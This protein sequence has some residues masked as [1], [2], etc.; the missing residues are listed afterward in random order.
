MHMNNAP[1]Y[2]E[3]KAALLGG[4]LPLS[5]LQN[6]TL[7]FDM[8]E[9][10]LPQPLATTEVSIAGFSELFPPEAPLPH[11]L[12]SFPTG[13]VYKRWRGNM[14]TLHQLMGRGGDDW[15]DLLCIGYRLEEMGHWV[16][17]LSDIR[18][19]LRLAGFQDLKPRDV[20]RDLA[21]LANQSLEGRKRVRFRAA[22]IALD[23]LRG[24][25]IVRQ[26]GLLP[27]TPIGTLP[28]R[29]K[30]GSFR[31]D[32]PPGLK[33][34]ET[35]P[36][37][38]R[39]VIRTVHFTALKLG[40]VGADN[41]SPTELLDAITKD[42]RVFD[43]LALRMKPN[44]LKIYR[45]RAIRSLGELDTRPKGADLSWEAMGAALRQILPEESRSIVDR[46]GQLRSAAKKAGVLP[47]GVT[48]ALVAQWLAEASQDARGSIRVGAR[49]LNE[50]FELGEDFARFL[51]AEPI[52][53]SAL[54]GGT[55]VART[56]SLK[57]RCG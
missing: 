53:R 16:G 6:W 22:C 43:D 12:H 32:V 31:I 28:K 7:S 48:T 18:P 11:A 5:N 24:H 50:M 37:H 10:A 26:A 27:S 38:I 44:S 1:T 2:A 21:L 20:I 3:M 29:T 54:P 40:L 35:Y 56:K 39:D 46:F 52:D 33:I 57:E 49:L 51:P 8:F 15:S 14:L 4:M 34:F 41:V 9:R 17:N 13:P 45:Q 30:S 42:D 19:S 23:L 36:V 55:R 25:E 47:S